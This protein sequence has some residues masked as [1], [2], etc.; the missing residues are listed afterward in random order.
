MSPQG[1]ELYSFHPASV[2]LLLIQLLLFFQVSFG[3]V[4]M[5]LIS[6]HRCECFTASTPATQN[7]QAP[8]DKKSTRQKR[9]PTNQ[10]QFQ[11]SKVCMF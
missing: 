5:H 11:R 8:K 10:A 1:C 7:P 3:S 4:P 2:L 6:F 9:I